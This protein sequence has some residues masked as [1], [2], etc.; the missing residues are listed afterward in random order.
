MLLVRVYAHFILL[1]SL[2]SHIKSY[3]RIISFVL[4]IIILCKR[5]EERNTLVSLSSLNSTFHHIISAAVNY[6]SSKADTSQELDP[7]NL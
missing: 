5:C 2:I 4:L 6:I 1:A 3:E 7:G